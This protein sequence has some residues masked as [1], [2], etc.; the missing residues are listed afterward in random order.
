MPGD[1]ALFEGRLVE[2]GGRYEEVARL[3]E[4]AG[5]T[6][7]HGYATVNS[8]LPLAY[9]SGYPAAAVARPGGCAR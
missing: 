5:D 9:G 4:A 1:V 7:R 3:A 2:A 8:V 6:Y